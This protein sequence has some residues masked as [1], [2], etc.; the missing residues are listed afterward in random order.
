MCA[1]GPQ[2]ND[3]EEHGDPPFLIESGWHPLLSGKDVSGWH[4]Q[5]NK[6]HEWFASSGIRWDRL[7]GPTRLSAVREPGG[8]ILNGPN[9]KTTNIVT[10]EKFG[11]SELYVEFLLA[12]G[13][14]SGVYLHGLYEVQVFDSYGSSMPIKSSDCGGI[15]HRWIDNEGVGGSAPM[16]NASRRPGEWQSFHIWFQAPK[17]DSG[18]K[19]IANAKFLRVLHNGLLVQQDV[20]VDGPTRAAMSHPEAPLNPIMLQGDHGPVAFRNIYIRPLRRLI[21]R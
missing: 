19:K 20:E 12:K 2:F 13:S 8:R 11:D 1:Q 4:A 18:G 9:G 14:N 5:D 16:V 21:D 6:P 10:D 15:Y 3:G 7:L 17:F